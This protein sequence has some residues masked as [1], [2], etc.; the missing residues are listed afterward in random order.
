MKRPSADHAGESANALSCVNLRTLPESMLTTSN[1]PYGPPHD[2]P[3]ATSRPSGEK[4]GALFTKPVVAPGLRADANSWP[5]CP[6]ESE[7]HI[8]PVTLWRYANER[9]SRDQAGSAAFKMNRR[10]PPPSAGT[11][12]ISQIP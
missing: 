11:F 1:S 4:R 3:K 9:P 2:E 10:G 8:A 12:Q 7:I 5:F 6:K